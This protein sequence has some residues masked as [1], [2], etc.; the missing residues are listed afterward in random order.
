MSDDASKNFYIVSSSRHYI[1]I[2]VK[3]MKYP[4]IKMHSEQESYL[5]FG[6]CPQSQDTL[7]YTN[8]F[9]K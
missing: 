6:Y 7:I 1:L 3:I 9:Y 2:E 4:E 5:I 8:K